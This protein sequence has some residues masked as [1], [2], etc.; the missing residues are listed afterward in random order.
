LVW[1]WFTI[2]DYR[3]SSEYQAKALTAWMSL[4]GKGDHSAVSVVST[5]V[6]AGSSGSLDADSEKNLMD[7]RSR[8]EGASRP[9]LEGLNLFNR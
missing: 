3:V 8:L 1:S 9:I 4:T 5:I 2:G 6:A 7:A